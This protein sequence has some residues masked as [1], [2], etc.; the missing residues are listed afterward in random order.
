MY[1][2]DRRP[3]R[4]DI[5]WFSFLAS[6]VLLVALVVALAWDSSWFAGRNKGE[7]P[8]ILFCAAGIKAPVAEIVAEYSEEFGVEVQIQ[9][10]GSETLLATIKETGAGDLYLPA[11]DSYVTLARQKD[12]LAEVIPLATMKPVLVVSTKNPKKIR[13]LDDVLA[14]GIRLSH[15]EPKAAAVGKVAKEAL[16][17]AGQWAAFEKNV[18]VTKMT[19]NDVAVDIKTGAADAGIIWDAL[20]QQL[21]GLKVVKASALEKEE[22]KLSLCVLRTC[23][24]PT[25]ALHFARYLAARD[26]GLPVF[27]KFG[28][29][30]VDGDPWTETPELK[31]L[32]G[33]MLRPAIEKTI[34]AFEERE[35]CKVTR[36]Y[37][38]CGI[39]VAQM[40]ADGK[41]PDAY[42]ACDKEFMTQVHDLFAP[43]L[44]VSSNQLVILV[45]KANKHKIETLADLGKPGLRVGIGHEKQ[46]AMGVLTQTT[47]RQT[48]TEKSVMK[49]VVVQVPAGDML[50]NQMKAGALDAAVAYISNA[51]GAKELKALPINIP[52]AFAEQPV[53]VGKQAKYPHMTARLIN[54]ILTEESRQLFKDNGFKWK[55]PK[56]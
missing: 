27:K 22:A 19:V 30:P 33:A 21:G 28:F 8:L 42:F 24:Q 9:Y 13:S 56:R 29:A 48:K 49:N 34:T 26:K 6:V 7:Q 46:C 3:A 14:K 39:L 50:V 10:G 36:V 25:R 11:D 51:A 2:R 1:P 54:A 15:A 37:N 5:T 12:M 38:G 43:P 53:A 55:A 31:L 41:S 47:L 23:N 44:T 18:I 35:G 32:A 16:Q 40:K 45:H 17:K 20:V 4:L 52:C